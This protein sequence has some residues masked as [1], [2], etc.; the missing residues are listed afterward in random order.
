[1]TVGVTFPVRVTP[2]SSRDAIEGV[3]PDGVLRVRVTAAP[4]DGAAN[5]A[6]LKLMAS[7]L[8]VPK[9]RVGLADG[10]TSRTKRLRVDGVD[11]EAILARW[12][13]ISLAGRIPQ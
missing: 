13:G 3:G 6:V 1:M 11:K 4:S 5:R 12:S 2:R 8:G 9:S 10:S 7:A